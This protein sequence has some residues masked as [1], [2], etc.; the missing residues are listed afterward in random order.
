MSLHVE[1]S[2]VIVGS[3]DSVWELIRPLDFKFLPNVESVESSGASDKKEADN[4]VGG[5]R[6]VQYKDNI[7]QTYKVLE[8]SDI[9]HTITYDLIESSPSVSFSSAVYTISLKRI[10]ESNSTFICW[11]TDFSNDAGQAEVQDS[12]FKKLEAFKYEIKNI[13]SNCRWEELIKKYFVLLFP[14]ISSI[15]NIDRKARV[16]ISSTYR[17]QY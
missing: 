15:K 14:I 13:I 16:G 7:K 6:I 12:K 10:T 2:A 1:E 9:H 17:V 5:L 8:L 11:T 4:A 3:I